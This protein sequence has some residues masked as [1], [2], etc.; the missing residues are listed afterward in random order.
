MAIEK[1]LDM[2]I[3]AFVTLVH[4]AAPDDFAVENHG[5]SIRDFTRTRHV[6]GNGKRCRAKLARAIDDQLVDDAGQDRVRPG[7]A[8]ERVNHVLPS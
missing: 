4:R 3:A 6:M 7:A 8:S 2:R 5:D 1:L